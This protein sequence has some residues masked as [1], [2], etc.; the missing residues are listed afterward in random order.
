MG[1]T[2]LEPVTLPMHAASKTPC[3]KCLRII[4]KV[5]QFSA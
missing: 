5:Q 2:G 1:L 4:L 3:N